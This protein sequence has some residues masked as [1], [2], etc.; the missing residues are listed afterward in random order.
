MGFV[1]RRGGTVFNLIK[2]T[3][4]SLDNQEFPLHPILPNVSAFCHC[5]FK[6]GETFIPTLRD[7]Y[8]YD[9]HFESGSIIRFTEIGFIRFSRCVFEAGSIIELGQDCLEASV[10]DCT[11]PPNECVFNGK[12][13][14]FL[15]HC[16]MHPMETSF[17]LPKSRFLCIWD[18]FCSVGNWEYLM[19]FR[20]P[21]QQDVYLTCAGVMNPRSLCILTYM[22]WRYP[23]FMVE[24]LT[25]NGSKKELAILQMMAKHPHRLEVS[26]V[27]AL[28][29]VL[30][31]ELIRGELVSFLIW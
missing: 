12:V 14:Y 4:M 24:D 27:L 9:C 31:S 15:T 1:K 26:C 30:P 2:H 17:G 18:G 28:L 16:R 21:S 20:I 10:D 7:R 23:R 5:R 13:K 8:M 19:P 25:F 11:F 6:E 29:S 3:K 22:I